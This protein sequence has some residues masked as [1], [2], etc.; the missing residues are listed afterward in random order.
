VY[1]FFVSGEP[2][3]Q[4]SMRAIT[5]S[6]RAR[7]FH[8]SSKSLKSW[9][10]KISERA[11]EELDGNFGYDE[12]VGVWLEFL[13]S[14]PKTVGRDLPETKPDLDKLV[15]AVLDALE[16]SGM[17]ANDSRVVQIFSSKVYA[18]RDE[19]PGVR[20]MLVSERE[21]KVGQTLH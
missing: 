1:E 6:G 8:D 7:V 4:G 21:G 15:R 12:P 10:K 20:I 2:K 19:S 5:V 18:E 11:S 13:L 9:R 17:I 3:P 14:R 16:S